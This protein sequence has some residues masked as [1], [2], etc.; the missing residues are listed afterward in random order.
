ML[1]CAL[2]PATPTADLDLHGAALDLGLA[3][4]H[5]TYDTLYVAFAVATGARAVIAADRAF[6]RDM[7]R[8]SDPVLAAMV[9]PLDAWAA[10]A[11][12]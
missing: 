12:T 11:P 6:V 8:H 9:I 1:L 7:A 5:S 3:V 2:L 4:D 10:L